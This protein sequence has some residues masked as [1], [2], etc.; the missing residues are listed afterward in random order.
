V[1]W[2][3]FR[4]RDVSL[5]IDMQYEDLARCLLPLQSVR[6]KPATDADEPLFNNVAVVPLEAGDDD[7]DPA[8]M[9][10][11]LTSPGFALVVSKNHT[12]GDGHT[13][14]RLYGMLD[15]EA[16]VEALDEA[17]IRVWPG[18]IR[19]A[20]SPLSARPGW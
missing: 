12:V 16:E 2:N 13:Y 3:R 14:Y 11:Q 19:L 18:P 1:K 6:S 4:A 7:A 20:D 8:P 17:K 9:Q 15:A 5:S 10:S